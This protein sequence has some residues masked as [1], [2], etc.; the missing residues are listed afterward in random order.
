M[1]KILSIATVGACLALPVLHAA[2]AAYINYG[3]TNNPQIDARVVVNYGLIQA[4]NNDLFE[5]QS[6][7]YLTNQS[8]GDF[9]GY[10]GFRFDYASATGRSPSINFIN[11]GLI[12]AFGAGGSLGGVSIG[13]VDGSLGPMGYLSGSYIL[14]SSDN[15]QNP[16]LMTTDEQGLI[17]LEGRNVDLTRGGMR[18][19]QAA[20][21]AVFGENRGSFDGTNY[22]NVAGIVDSRPSRVA[23]NTV[24]IAQLDS[25]AGF[26]PFA[27]TNA[28]TESNFTVQ[29]IYVSTN[30]V[31][32]NILASVRFAP[33]DSTMHAE[34]FQ[35]DVINDGMIG[36]VQLGMTNLDIIT[37]KP[38]TNFVYVLDTAAMAGAQTNWSLMT[39][40][41]TLPQVG[42]RPVSFEV[43]RTTPME[44]RAGTTNNT[45]YTNTLLVNPAY[46]NTAVTNFLGVYNFEVGIPIAQGNVAGGQDS[47]YGSYFSI[48]EVGIQEPTNWPG[49][50]EID[51]S[52]L[53]LDRARIRA[54]SMIGLKADKLVYKEDPLLDAPHLYL[55]LG[56]D[57]GLLVVSNL[58]AQSV[59]RMA[60]SVS[61]ETHIYTNQLLVAVTN[62]PEGEGEPTIETNALDVKTHVLLVDYTQ[63]K[64]DAVVAAD[65]VRFRGKNVDLYDRINANHSL[66]IDSLGLRNA[67]EINVFDRLD[68]LG[69]PNFPRMKYL[70]NLGTFTVPNQFWIGA[71]RATPYESIVNGGLMRSSSLHI[72]AKLFEN[73]GR[74]FATG[75]PVEIE[76]TEAAK[77][78]DGTI[79]AAALFSLTAG[80]IKARNTRVS[81]GGFS[82]NTDH[83]ADGGSNVWQTYD[84]F[85]LVRKPE[86]DLFGFDIQSLPPVFTQ[87]R[88]IW[89]AEDR[90]NTAAGFTNN[91]VIGRLFLVPTNFSSFSFEGVGGNQALYVDYLSITNVP[92]NTLAS[93]IS[94]AEGFNVYFADA[95]V[96]VDLLD[97][98]SDGRLRW[99]KSF[100]GP[101]SS[102]GMPDAYGKT[103][104]YNRALRNHRTID[105]DGDGIANATDATPFSGTVIK[106][107]DV[108]ITPKP[109]ALITWP[110]VTNFNYT[111]QYVTNLA[112]V[113]WQNL[114]NLTYKGTTNGPVTVQD[115]LPKNSSQRYYRVL[116]GL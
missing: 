92:T 84:G 19:G 25:P 98:L 111:V 59:K 12:E 58:V 96:P 88:H 85:Q 39:N 93:V 45:I 57:T 78:D 28:I 69:A 15:I 60:G 24:R 90:G 11:K 5:T 53:I 66:V 16:G 14:V 52:T 108:V 77:L 72:K 40:I 100:A 74:L 91:A 13:L 83:I 62:A 35:P 32:S 23:T 102:I 7:Q 20:E 101:N 38:F 112:N 50:V 75:G 114:T 95:N 97:G 51:A 31:D 109:A 94:V 6:T 54:E 4:V 113:N 80:E 86:G 79:S 44:W 17:R 61:V 110:A 3:S 37:G 43:T 47:I 33:P 104:Y 41:S 49:R 18:A 99:S 81:A 105:S 63:L 67:G 116:Y 115:V 34:Y 30:G 46:A 103:N 56:T 8:S 82:I 65:E 73:S 64:A 21:E 55:D 87:A 70:T 1:K 106:E 36:V 68:S 29:V 107:I 76:A 10:P 48:Y 89:A 27:Y 71:D 26:A 9:W 22:N 42:T 2:D